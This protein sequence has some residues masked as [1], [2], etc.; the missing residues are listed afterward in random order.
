MSHADHFL[1]RLDRVAHSH[2]HIELA[3]SLYRD[4]ALLRELLSRARVPEGVERVALSLR[5]PTTGPFLVVTRDG[6]FVTCLAAGMSVS[7][8]HVV[9]RSQLDAISATVRDLRTRVETAKRLTRPGQETEAILSRLRTAGPTLSREEFIGISAWA[10]MLSLLFLRTYFGVGAWLNEARPIL[11]NVRGETPTERHELHKFHNYYWALGHLALL[12][13]SEARKLIDELGDELPAHVLKLSW[14]TTR[15]G[16]IGIALRGAWAVGKL[17]KAALPHYKR[18]LAEASTPA[19]LSDSLL[20]L[21]AIGHR[22]TTLQAEV[23]KALSRALPPHENELFSANAELAR[24][25]ALATIE[26]IETSPDELWQVARRHGGALVDVADRLPPGSPFRFAKHD[27]VPDD[28]VRATMLNDVGN[29]FER[30]EL[31]AEALLIV[32][33]A[34]RCKMEDFYFPA[35]IS[36]HVFDRWEPRLT[37]QLLRLHRTAPVKR[38]PVRVERGRDRNAPCPCGSGRKLKKC[39]GAPQRQGTD[40]GGSAAPGPRDEEEGQAR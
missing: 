4:D 29:L 38:E 9:P 28:L 35:E 36:R 6:R 32:P 34:A 8:A 31:L 21:S 27:D 24:Q 33:Y 7:D 30:I 3:L 15:L 40:P 20:A 1:S 12:A 25:T 5:D 11:A 2:E 22:N 26:A 16:T 37:L 13:G 18:Q 14:P 17:G 39:C 19:T 10:P 23:R